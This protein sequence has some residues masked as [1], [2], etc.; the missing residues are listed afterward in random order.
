[1]ILS[2]RLLQQAVQYGAQLDQQQP[3]FQPF[4][5]VEHTH[6]ND[7][8]EHEKLDMIQYHQ[9]AFVCVFL[10]MCAPLQHVMSCT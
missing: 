10:A 6:Q 4:T 1:M 5:T 9:I 7:K 3:T 2:S 8:V